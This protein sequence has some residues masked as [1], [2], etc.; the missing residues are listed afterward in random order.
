MELVS[1]KDLDITLSPSKMSSFKQIISNAVNQ[2]YTTGKIYDDADVFC[3]DLF[4]ILFPANDKVV[5]PTIPEPAPTP[6]E[7]KEE[8]KKKLTKEEKEA[9]K[10]AKEAKKKADAEAK[11]AKKKA[12]EEAKA[13]KEAKKKADE[14][15]KAAKA[16]NGVNLEKLNPSQT[17]QLKAA[18]DKVKV[19]LAKDANKK[20]I[21]FVNELDKETYNSKK[22]DAHMADFVQTLVPPPEP[23]PVEQEDAWEVDWK[24]KKYSVD[25]KG[26]VYEEVD[27]VDK[28]VGMV[29][30]A[31]FEGMEM[32]N[33]DE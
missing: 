31:Y 23:A 24:D 3:N 21:E 13:A 20:F 19:T 5:V 22:L 1:A 4:E 16:A 28:A 8:P 32:P 12:D 25:K 26:R 27:G 10:A 6:V 7:K 15:A 14:A 11:E 18:A 9:E 33:F 17:K 30:I 29:G 2:L